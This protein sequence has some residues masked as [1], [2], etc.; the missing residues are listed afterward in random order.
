MP[1]HG[2]AATHCCWLA[3]EVC[4]HLEENTV[5]GRR[6]ACGLMRKLGNWDLVLHSEE[7]LRD[8]EPILKPFGYNCKDWPDKPKGAKCGDCG[9]GIENAN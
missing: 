2:N 7:Y 3:G 4:P 8:V 1:C 6:W 9:W 5:V